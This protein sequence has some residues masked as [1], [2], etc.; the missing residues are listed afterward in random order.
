MRQDVVALEYIYVAKRSRE[1]SK[2]LREDREL[3]F[4]QPWRQFPSRN[5]VFGLIYYHGLRSRDGVE[6]TSMLHL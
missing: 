3:N 4:F 5:R 1:L 6:A 2:W